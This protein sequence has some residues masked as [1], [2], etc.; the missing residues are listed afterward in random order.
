MNKT[1]ET[2]FTIMPSDCNYHLPMVFGGAFFSKL[3]LAAACCVSELLADSPNGCD[4]AVTYKY[5]GTFHS[6]AEM[7]DLIYVLVEVVELRH[8]SIRMLVKAHR[9]K[10]ASKKR[11]L[12]AEAEFVFVTKKGESF[13][14]HG[15]VL[16]EPYARVS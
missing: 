3:D 5:S 10:R 9:A 13:C 11:D 2:N 12:V 16:D 8:K 7:G 15:L 14:N 4:S 6:A 1:F